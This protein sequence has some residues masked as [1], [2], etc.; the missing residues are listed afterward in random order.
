MVDRVR[1]SRPRTQVA[2]HD[3]VLKVMS[4]GFGTNEEDQRVIDVRKFESEPAYVRVN[5]GATR[6]TGQYESFR[7]DVSI[8]IPCYPEEIDEVVGRVADQVSSYLDQEL[9]KYGLK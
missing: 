9:E 8:S 1:R 3:T 4:S 6:N 5:A 7:V 2:V